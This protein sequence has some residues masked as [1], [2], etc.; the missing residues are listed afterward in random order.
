VILELRVITKN[1]RP[2]DWNEDE[3]QRREMPRDE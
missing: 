1:I 2:S 3:D